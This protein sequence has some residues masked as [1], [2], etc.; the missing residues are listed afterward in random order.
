M[1][2]VTGTSS[3]IAVPAGLHEVRRGAATLASAPADFAATGTK[4]TFPGAFFVEEVFVD[5]LQEADHQSGI[6]E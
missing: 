5:F 3:L 1:A 6:G 4:V 2:T